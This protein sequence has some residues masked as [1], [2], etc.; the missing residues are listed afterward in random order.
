MGTFET[1]TEQ[2]RCLSVMVYHS[3]RDGRENFAFGSPCQPTSA[4]RGVRGCERKT[5]PGQAMHAP[6]RTNVEETDFCSVRG[7]LCCSNHGLWALGTA[8]EA[9]TLR[10]PGGKHG[11]FGFDRDPGRTKRVRAMVWKVPVLAAEVNEAR[12]NVLSQPNGG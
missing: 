5:R 2:H 1:E 12:H 4:V 10:M 7:N 8:P 9:N 11:R 3:T 6:S